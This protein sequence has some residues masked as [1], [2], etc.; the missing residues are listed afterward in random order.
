[1]N[2]YCENGA[3]RIND[4]ATTRRLTREFFAEHSISDL[5]TKSDMWLN[6]QGRLTE[7]MVKQPDSDCYE[8]IGWDDAF[9]LLAAQL[10]GLDSPD[11]ALFYTS[12]RVSN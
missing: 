1:M 5:A 7:P 11:E 9:D 3:K 10:L 4:E 2:E 6:Q 12:G 8:P